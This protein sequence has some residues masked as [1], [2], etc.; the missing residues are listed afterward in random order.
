MEE[1]T[2][3]VKRTQK[4]YTMSF[5]VHG[6]SRNRKR[7]TTSSDIL[8]IWLLLVVYQPEIYLNEIPSKKQNLL[9]FSCAFA[10]NTAEI[11]LH[12]VVNYIRTK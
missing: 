1:H 5:N 3:Y 4:N 2:N 12:K 8:F 7:R 9:V 10:E 11:H 6:C